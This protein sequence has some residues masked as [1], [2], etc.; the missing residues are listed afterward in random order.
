MN[1]LWQYQE[2]P[3]IDAVISELQRPLATEPLNSKLSADFRPGVT[4]EQLE[5]R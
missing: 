4:C 1:C 5:Q 2:V 3:Q